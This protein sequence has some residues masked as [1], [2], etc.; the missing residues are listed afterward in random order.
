VRRGVGVLDDGA[1]EDIL[2]FES[3]L[4]VSVLAWLRGAD[5]EDFAG[6]RFEDGVTALAECV[7]LAREG[8]GCACVAG[9]LAAVSIW[10]TWLWELEGDLPQ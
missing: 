9:S 10:G 5:L 8:E 6:L 2:A 4:C 7:C 1:S 3:A